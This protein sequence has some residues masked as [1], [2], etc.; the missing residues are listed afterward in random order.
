[1]TAYAK[2]MGLSN[3]LL[4]AAG[5]KSADR[6]LL[7][8]EAGRRADGRYFGTDPYWIVFKKPV[9]PYVRDAARKIAIFRPGT[10]KSRRCGCRRTACPRGG[11]RR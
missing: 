7:V 4:R 2:G 10:A 11:K 3:A 8:G 6:H 9:E 1:M 5:G